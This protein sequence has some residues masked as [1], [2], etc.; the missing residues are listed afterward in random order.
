[1]LDFLIM[2]FSDIPIAGAYWLGTQRDQK[3]I[4]SMLEPW[5]LSH[6]CSML[7]TAFETSFCRSCLG[8]SAVSPHAIFI[9]DTFCTG[10][11]N[12]PAGYLSFAAINTALRHLV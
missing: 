4:K 10:L 8:Y 11:G 3:T 2:I 9:N 7:S 6:L 1:M 5:T 12:C